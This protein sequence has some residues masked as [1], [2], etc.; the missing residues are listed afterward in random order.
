MSAQLSRDIAKLMPY[1]PLCDLKGN[2]LI[3]FGIA[4]DKA[5]TITDLS[6]TYQKWIVQANKKELKFPSL[7]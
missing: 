6:K 3:K 2:K 7:I 1:L 5:E 4:I